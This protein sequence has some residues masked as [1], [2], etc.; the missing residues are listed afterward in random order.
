MNDDGDLL[1]NKS[2][3]DEE[4]AP[5]TNPPSANKALVDFVSSLPGDGDG[6]ALPPTD[7]RDSVEK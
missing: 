3:S 6:T 1:F 2:H 7:F 5:T 4:F